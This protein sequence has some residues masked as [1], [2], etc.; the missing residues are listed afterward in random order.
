MMKKTC[1]NPQELA[2]GRLHKAKGRHRSRSRHPA[3][4]LAEQRRAEAALRQSEERYRR[5]VETTHEGIWMA[6]LNGIT[7]F[8][9]PQMSRMLGSTPEQMI[10]RPVFDFVFEEDC[11]VVRQHFAGF[12]QQPAGKRVEERLRRSDGAELWAVVAASVVLDAHRQPVGF[13][14]MFTD[15]TERKRMEEVLRDAQHTLEMRVRERTAELQA[16][17]RAVA[18]S[19]D[20]YRRLFETISDAAFVFEAE[21]RQFVEVNE[22][23]LRLYGYTREEF[24]KLTHH[25]ITAEPE[26][27]EATIQLTLAGGAPRIPLRYHKKKDGTIFP[28]E[29]SASTLALKG[30]PMACGIIRDITTRKQAEET[31]RRRERELADFFAESP[32]G[33]LWV[34]PDGRILRVNQAELELL[35][36]IG[37]EIF[38]RHVSKLHVDAKAA[39][40]VL[41][42]VAERQ[43]VQNY[44]ARLRH[45]DGTQ[46]EVLIDA[47]GL[48]EQERLVHS[49]WFTRDITR[50]VELEREIL[51]ISEREQRRLGHDL[52][53]DLCQQLAGIEFLSQRL[54]SDLEGRSAGGAPQAKEIAGMV[55]RAMTQTRELARGLSPVRLEA[56]GLGDALRELALGT[57]K[58][59]GCDCRFHCDPPVLV[60]DHTVA[61]HLYRIAQE[62]VSNAIRH[63]QAR[64]IAIAL[65][66]KGRS[67]TLAMKDNGTGIP[68]KPPKRKGIGLRI[69]RYRAEVIGGTLLVEPVP[70]GGTR[71]ECTVTNGPLPPEAR[72]AK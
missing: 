52:H 42:R 40:D 56:D 39:A 54:A 43:T 32:L 13:L 8:V 29:I 53:D 71:V 18:E 4:D 21:S 47:N 25:A 72:N 11:A 49:R 16:S 51:A 59:F 66:A 5:I 7:T 1:S 3:G 38:G 70:S 57:R 2:P 34:G 67:V 50:R 61:I 45:R 64:R 19:E 36:R 65:T 30:R 55:Q 41:N 20:K 24:L 10:E 44:R 27:S 33:L 26:D 37:D 28:V 58:V 17:H 12:L 6:D 31:L 46:R 63:G 48:W 22:A 23:A 15:I 35:G 69:M 68:R 14:G 62:A 9:N 60:P